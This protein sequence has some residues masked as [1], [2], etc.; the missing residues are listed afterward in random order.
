MLA[1]SSLLFFFCLFLL[2]STFF[3]L[4]PGRLLLSK[5]SKQLTPLENGYLSI[6]LGFV[7]IILE[8]VITGLLHLRIISWILILSLSFV[9]LFKLGFPIDFFRNLWRKR[10]LLPVLF[11]GIIV[12]GLIN[13][14]SGWKFADGVNFWSSQ[15]HDGLWHVS[16]M[17]EVSRN[18]PPSMPLYAGHSLTNYHYISDIFMGEYYRLFPIF[19]SLDLYFRFY[20]VLFS[21]LIGL[22]VFVLVSRI[23]DESSALWAMFFT[24]FCG[25]FGYIVA[26]SNHQFMFSGETAFWASQGNTI[27]G[28]PPH[29]LGIIFLTSILLLIS[30]WE[31]FRNKYLLFLLCLI[32]FN[33]AGVK[34]SSGAILVLGMLTIGIFSMV[35]DRN[36]SLLL[37]GL[38]VAVGNFLTLKIISPTAQSFIIFEPLWFPRTM[39][40]VRLNNVDWEMRRQHYLSL[41]TWRSVVHLILHEAGAILLFIAGNTAMRL[42]GLFEILH[43]SIREISLVYIFMITGILGATVTVLLFVQ[44]GVTFNLIQFFQ[45]TQHLLGIFAGI[46]VAAILVKIKPLPL[47][48]FVA[49]LVIALSIPTTIGNIYDFYG[50]GKNPL[51][52]VSNPELEGLSWIKQNTP[53]EAI[54]FTK[55]FDVN[56]RYR[57]KTQPMPIAGWYSTMYVHSFTGRHTFLTGEEQLNITGYKID[58]DLK[59]SYDFMKQKDAKKDKLFLDNSHIDYLYFRKDELD[60]PINDKALNLKLVFSNSEVLIYQND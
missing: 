12:Q 57:Y 3:I 55:A 16:L 27:I 40:V 43:Q 37:T 26:I 8:T 51:A 60:F 22:G 41:H 32:G 39:M 28:N 10:F 4:L 30:L 5:L 34:V 35:K 1:I 19:S 24:Y 6:I 45:I 56:A 7:I 17:E 48:L 18:F 52:Q 46:S 38:V 21:F 33:L 47:K 31:K 2:S 44:S 54:I 14:P 15:G 58:E 9:S 42:I 13:F 11:I 50:P 53:P 20:P 59:K 29:T 23:K 25:S 49:C 36:P